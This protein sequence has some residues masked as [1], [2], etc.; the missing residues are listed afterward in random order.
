[1]ASDKKP[2]LNIAPLPSKR[3]R[4]QTDWFAVADGF[5]LC[6]RSAE[7]PGPA[8]GTVI[9][10]QSVKARSKRTFKGLKMT[11]GSRCATLTL[12]RSR[13]HRN[14]AGR[15]HPG[16]ASG[17]DARIISP[18]PRPCASSSLLLDCIRILSNAGAILRA[19]KRSEPPSAF[20]QVPS[21][22]NAEMPAEPPPAPV[23]SVSSIATR[24]RLIAAAAGWQKK[25]GVL[26]M[27]HASQRDRLVSDGC[28]F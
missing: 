26:P 14:A 23:F 15:H 11:R 27:P 5:P 3:A 9:V 22:F 20:L 19:A 25:R 2:L 6:S 28:E 18:S 16:E 10:S 12:A 8:I 17:L 13:P 7:E 21:S 1:L 24:A 4:S